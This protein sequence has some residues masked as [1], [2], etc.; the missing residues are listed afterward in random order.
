MYS[1]RR[2][3]LKKKAK[4]HN[5]KRNRIKR[6]SKRTKRTKRK[7][8]GGM[9]RRQAI[10]VL[11]LNEEM[12]NKIITGL[13]QYFNS[14]RIDSKE[15]LI[16]ELNKEE[17]VELFKG[18]LDYSFSFSL[19]ENK[20]KLIINSGILKYITNITITQNGN[21]TFTFSEGN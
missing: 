18:E 9:Q 7:Y 4:T 15:A 16:Q 13:N 10:K 19:N 17:R 21:N 8:I 3:N 6:K 11:P 1:K 12:I 20:D 14:K 5:K 2:L